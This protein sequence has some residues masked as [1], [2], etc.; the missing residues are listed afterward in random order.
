MTTPDKHG[1]Q[2]FVKE[3]GQQLTHA[4]TTQPHEYAYPLSEV[5]LVVEK[6][7]RAFLAGSFNK[8][9]IALRATC[10]A[11]KI[12]HTYRDIEMYLGRD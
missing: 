4:I 7:G 6:M 12:K 5:P 9:G 8:D 2:T 1:Y 3:Y 11:L 10:K